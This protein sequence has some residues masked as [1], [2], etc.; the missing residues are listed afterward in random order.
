MQRLRPACMIWFC[1]MRVRLSKALARSLQGGSKIMIIIIIC[2]PQCTTT[3]AQR[4]A[5]LKKVLAV[6]LASWL[7]WIICQWLMQHLMLW[8]AWE[9]A[10]AHSSKSA[11]IRLCFTTLVVC[12]FCRIYSKRSKRRCLWKLHLLICKADTST[13]LRYDVFW[14]REFA[15]LFMQLL[16]GTILVMKKVLVMYVV[17]CM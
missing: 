17:P 5:L 15:L 8:K 6:P 3:L 11:T 13:G 4:Y 9:F 12:V 2:L 16:A 7:G 14:K 10:Q 1:S